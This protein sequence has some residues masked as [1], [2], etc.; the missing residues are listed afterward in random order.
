VGGSRL[1][2]GTCQRAETLT[3]TA[4]SGF[5]GAA[6]NSPKEGDDDGDTY[7]LNCGSGFTDRERDVFWLSRDN[8]IGVLVE[9]RADAK[10]KSQDSDTYSLRFPRFKCFRGFDSDEKI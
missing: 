10:T 5:P 8:L 4:A 6:K 9:I 1:L 7:H 3:G 2:F